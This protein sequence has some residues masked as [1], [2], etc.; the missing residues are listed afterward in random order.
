MLMVVYDVGIAL[1]QSGMNERTQM[2]NAKDAREFQKNL[3]ELD[4]K[5]AEVGEIIRQNIEANPNV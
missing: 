5:V 1:R 2:F 3:R 4:A